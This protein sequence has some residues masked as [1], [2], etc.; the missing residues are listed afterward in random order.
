M[1]EIAGASLNKR[2]ISL[3]LCFASLS[4]AILGL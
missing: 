1:Q 2:K 4:L 3:D